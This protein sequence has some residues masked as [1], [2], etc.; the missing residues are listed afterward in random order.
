M[1]GLCAIFSI[2]QAI[3]SNA[4]VAFV[5]VLLFGGA[6]WLGISALGYSEFILAR[7]LLRGAEFQRAVSARVSLRSL[8]NALAR[9]SDIQQCWRVL[10]A[11]AGAFGFDRIRLTAGDNEFGASWSDDAAHFT[12]RIPLNY[13]GFIELQRAFGSPAF[14]MAVTLFIDEIRAGTCRILAGSEREE[15][16][17]MS[18]SV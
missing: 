8:K 11:H 16:R 10:Q 2:T 14:P 9:A 18:S 7:E 5:L 6:A 12:I 1:A 17:A 15:T 13:D 4:Y 3:V